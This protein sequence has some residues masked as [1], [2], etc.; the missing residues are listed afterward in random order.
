MPFRNIVVSKIVGKSPIGSMLYIDQLD[1][2]LVRMGT[3]VGSE[4]GILGSSW[5]LFRQEQRFNSLDIFHM[6]IPRMKEEYINIIQ[7]MGII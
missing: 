7:V 1:Q 3:F 6:E 5:S 4:G 2:S